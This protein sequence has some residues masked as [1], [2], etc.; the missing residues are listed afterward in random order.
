[1]NKANPLYK[2]HILFA[3][4]LMT[5]SVFLLA[6]N[7]IAFSEQYNIR[8]IDFVENPKRLAA[9]F[10]LQHLQGDTKQEVPLNTIFHTGDKFQFVIRPNKT[11]HLY[12][13]NINPEGEISQI[14]PNA[15]ELSVTDN[16]V[17]PGKLN[18]IPENGHFKFVGQAGNEWL[19]VALSNV[20]KNPNLNALH[21]DI[22]QYRQN[23]GKVFEYKKIAQAS[24][25]EDIPQF[26]V[27]G[28]IAETNEPKEDDPGTYG[29][30]VSEGDVT[31]VY[32]YLLKHKTR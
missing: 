28:I 7:K 11:A 27:R 8:S 19:I 6:D 2:R 22:K 4:T 31:L 26:G 1:M 21:R 15:N 17:F 24:T 29:A 32:P 30:Q 16:R 18:N 13:I 5:L 3:Y 14:W 12:V 20:K 23:Q 9:R 25:E 10:T